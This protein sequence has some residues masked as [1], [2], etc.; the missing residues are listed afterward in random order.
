MSPLE[1]LL[2]Q[3][4]ATTSLKVYAYLTTARRVQPDTGN[5]LDCLVPFLKAGVELQ[6]HDAILDIG[7]LQQFLRILGLSIPYLVLDNFQRRLA[8]LDILTRRGNE[9]HVNNIFEA[10]PELERNL[11]ALD[12]AFDMIEL[13]LSKFAGSKFRIEATKFF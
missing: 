6:E 7:A 10:I 4:K 5:V 1:M 13:E 8:E 9:Y 11:Y 2:Q 3:R 12:Q